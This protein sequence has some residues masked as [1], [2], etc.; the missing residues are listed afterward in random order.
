[1]VGSPLRSR[2]LSS[3][4][5]G[6]PASSCGVPVARGGVGRVPHRQLGGVPEVEEVL[7]VIVLG[8][9]AN[10]GTCAD[11]VSESCGERCTVPGTRSL[12]H[13]TPP[14]GAVSQAEAPY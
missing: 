7:Q 8:E 1:M 5:L 11:Y 3:R 14:P 9:D 6:V 13:P 4:G 10:S 2:L 12:K